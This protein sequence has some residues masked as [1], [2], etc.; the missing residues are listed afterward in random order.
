MC[1]FD[2]STTSA[3][4][5]I[6]SAGIFFLFSR[7]N[8]SSYLS[9]HHSLTMLRV[10]FP[11]WYIPTYSI[12]SS[13]FGSKLSCYDFFIHGFSLYLL[14][15]SYFK[16]NSSPQFLN[17]AQRMSSIFNS[18]LFYLFTIKKN[19]LHHKFRHHLLFPFANICYKVI[20]NTIHL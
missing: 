14:C 17:A 4:H 20:S 18:F 12:L 13:S 16:P 7:N 10:S 15:F 3:T 8:L 11:S 1:R 19:F 9:L 5:L 2:P 6:V